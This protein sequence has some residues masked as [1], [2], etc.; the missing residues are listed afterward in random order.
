MK[1]RG[2]EAACGKA[3]I[4][5][6]IC[7]LVCS[8]APLAL[9]PRSVCRQ[10]L[11]SARAHFRVRLRRSFQLSAASAPTKERLFCLLRSRS[12]LFLSQLLGPQIAVGLARWNAIR[13]RG[14]AFAVGAGSQIRCC[15]FVVAS[16]V[17]SPE[18]AG[19]LVLDKQGNSR[20][21][22]TELR[23]KHRS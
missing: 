21:R 12:Q 23:R 11:A 2:G 16:F 19:L 17:T 15:G 3:A 1:R 9:G 5:S 18:R 7:L 6:R 20:W 22:S 14:Q 13:M 10:F 8:F 4:S